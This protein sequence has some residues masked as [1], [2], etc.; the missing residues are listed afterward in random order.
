MVSLELSVFF[1]GTYLL[2]ISQKKISF[3]GVVCILLWYLFA[4]NKPEENKFISVKEVKYLH[5]QIGAINQQNGRKSKGVPWR[6]MFISPVTWSIILAR[7]AFIWEITIMEMFLPS[8]FRDVLYLNMTANGLF[9]A[10]P[11]VAQL[12]SKNGCAIV[13]D[14]LRSSGKIGMTASTKIVECIAEVQPWS[15][16]SNAN[17]CPPKIQPL[18]TNDPKKVQENN[19]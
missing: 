8:Y 17:M 11:F 15:K 1:F 2:R 3:L 10:L 9:T 13:A 19:V 6:R 16:F 14:Y 7:F 12:I 18:E 4:T 5:Q